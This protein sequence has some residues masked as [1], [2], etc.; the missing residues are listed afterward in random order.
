MLMISWSKGVTG[1]NDLASGAKGKTAEAG[2]DRGVAAYR[3]PVLIDLG[4]RFV[5]QEVFEVI[6]ALFV[7]KSWLVGNGQQ[8][9]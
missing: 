1:M 5:M 7:G 6:D 8:E 3:K 2:I 4:Y 9:Y